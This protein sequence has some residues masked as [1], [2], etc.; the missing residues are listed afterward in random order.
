MKFFG[1]DFR[2][3]NYS[4]NDIWLFMVFVKEIKKFKLICFGLWLRIG[5]VKVCCDWV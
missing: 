4:I 2:V 5:V 3:I 1:G